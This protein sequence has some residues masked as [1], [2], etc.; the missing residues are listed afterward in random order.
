MVK[1]AEVVIIGGGVIGSSIAYYLAKEGCRDVVVL[2]R[3]Y[4]TWGASGRCGAGIRQQWGTEMNCR[5]AKGSVELFQGLSEELD[6][7]IEFEQ[8]GY[9]VL[10]TSHAQLE[11]YR[12]NVALQN[13]LGIPSKMVTPQEAKEIVPILRTDGLPGA[14]YCPTDGHANPFKANLAYLQAAQ[15]L[16]VKLFKFTEAKGVD[17][18]GGRVRGVVT[19]KGR[20]ETTKVVNAAGGY[21]AEV[22]KLAGL[23]IPTFSERHQIMVTEPLDHLF[24]PM[25]ISFTSG[26]YCQ[27]VP[28]GSILMG[29]GDPSEPHSHNITSSWQFLQKMAREVL[30][31]L[32]ILKDIRVVRQWA[33]LYN[34]TPDAQPILGQAE[35]VEGFY[36]AVGFS[37]HGFMI[38]P[39]VSLILA[40]LIMGRKSPISVE[41]LS[42]ERYERGELVIE[43]SVVG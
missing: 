36:M 2:E 14:A 16:G 12:R 38:A 39:M 27:Q 26:L 17:V 7:D 18:K 10:A 37:G 42:L 29:M 40:R 20:I 15:R 8:G 3:E 9:L 30:K 19:S 5:L 21:S 34:K 35:K 28:P 4:P 22:G 33:G 25:V 24:D 23:E 41:R 43:P 6:Y 32:P 11:Q 31:I 13:S 1:G